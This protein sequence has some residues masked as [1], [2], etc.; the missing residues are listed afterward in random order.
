MTP[1]QRK[2]H[3]GRLLR[4]V[5]GLAPAA[6]VAAVQGAPGDNALVRAG[7]VVAAAS[8]FELTPAGSAFV[9]RV[10]K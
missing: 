1:S 4:A 3:A 5:A 2:A 9:E 10:G 7:L 8:G 6:L